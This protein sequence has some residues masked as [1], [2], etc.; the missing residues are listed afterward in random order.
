MVLNGS[1]ILG[2]ALKRQGA[3]TFFYM[4][5]FFYI[6]GGPMMAAELAT[7]G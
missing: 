1:E 4:D 6:R 7:M 5:T 2:R 3:D